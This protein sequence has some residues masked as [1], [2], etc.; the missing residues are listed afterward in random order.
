MP[1][2]RKSKVTTKRGIHTK[3]RVVLAI[4]LI[5]SFQLVLFS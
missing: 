3:T 1:G 4:S 2:N 5:S